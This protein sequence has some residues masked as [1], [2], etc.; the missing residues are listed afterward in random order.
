MPTPLQLAVTVSL[1]GSVA[2]V[3]VP[4][5]VREFRSSR[6]AEATDGLATIAGRASALAA[7]APVELAY[8]PPAPLTPARVPAGRP[9]RAPSGAWEHPSWRLLD[10]RI[11]GAHSYAFQF[12]SS[13][14]GDRAYF[15]ASAYGDLD[16]DG[17]LSEFRVSGEIARGGQPVVYPLQI[18]R[19]VE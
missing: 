3:F 19:E 13:A 16:A 11:E 5:F 10:F 4:T 6:L 14:H 18:H 8:P 2:F 9:E 1:V 7:G 17:T 12:D 15:D